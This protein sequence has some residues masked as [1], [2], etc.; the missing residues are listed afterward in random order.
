MKYLKLFESWLNEYNASVLGPM[1][2]KLRTEI[3]KLGAGFDNDDEIVEAIETFG[4]KAVHGRRKYTADWEFLNPNTKENKRY[5]SYT[6]GYVRVVSDSFSPFTKFSRGPINK[7]KL[8]TTKDR[9]LFIL[10]RSMKIANMY[11]EWKK[12]DIPV[13]EFIFD[14]R[15]KLKGQKFGI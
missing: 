1:P 12:T 3:D 4:L 7:C 5:I 14:N 13:K 9:L 10:R 2:Q 15:G 6:S 8:E 11:E